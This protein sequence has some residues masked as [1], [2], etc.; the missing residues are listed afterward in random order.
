M[1]QDDL[2]VMGRFIEQYGLVQYRPGLNYLRDGSCEITGCSTLRASFASKKGSRSGW[3]VSEREDSPLYFDHCHA[4][5]WIRG[6]VCASCNSVMRHLDKH[7]YLLRYRV[8]LREAYRK[9]LNQCHDCEQ[10]NM[11]PTDQEISYAYTLTL[12]DCGFKSQIIK[13]RSKSMHAVAKEH[14]MTLDNLV[15][16]IRVRYPEPRIIAAVRK[17]PYPTTR[18]Q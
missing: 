3:T 10:I 18:P 11:L 13:L 7:G 6:L 14:G 5:G 8:D 2:F 4:H 12:P 17:D 1:Q 15:T 16:L 9:H